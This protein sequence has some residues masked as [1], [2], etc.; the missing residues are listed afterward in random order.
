MIRFT[1]DCCGCENC[2]KCSFGRKRL[3]VFCDECHREI[4]GMVYESDGDH[5]CEDCIAELEPQGVCC[6]CGC[7]LDKEA[8]TLDGKTYCPD[9]VGGELDEVLLNALQEDLV[10]SAL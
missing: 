7:E 6:E 8:Y 3:A 10:G 4:C 5:Y 1:S 9:C 2:V